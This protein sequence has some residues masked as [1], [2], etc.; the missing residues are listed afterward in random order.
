MN[1]NNVVFDMDGTFCDLYGVDN[2]LEKITSSDCSPFYEAQ[3]LVD[4][5]TL[6]V[7]IERIKAKGGKAILNTWLPLD[8]TKEFKREVRKAKRQ[9]VKYH[10]L[11][12]DEIHIISYGTPKSRCIAKKGYSRED[13]ILVDDNLSVVKKWKDKFPYAILA[14]GN[15]IETLLV[16]L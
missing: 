8:A 16:I 15:W 1:I 7:V 5:S 6:Q 2:W 11:Q 9:W 4:I 12:F 13:T 14:S 3:P 10:E